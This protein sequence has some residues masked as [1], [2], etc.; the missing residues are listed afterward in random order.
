MAVYNRITFAGNG[1]QM[2]IRVPGTVAAEI[3]AGEF[4]VLTSNKAIRASSLGDSGTLA[5]NQQAFKNVFQG[6]SMDG[7]LANETR[8]IQIATGGEYCH[9]CAALGQAYDAGQFIGAA[10]TGSANA[11]G[12]SDTIVI[13]V[14]TAA[15]A[16]GKLSR[17]A[18]T[19]DTKLYWYLN[20]QTSTTGGVQATVT[21]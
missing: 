15:L 3:K 18:A 19:G 10:G 16:I 11:V 20:P 21:S 8:D 5:Q 1:D 9:P 14:A 4:M 2:P 7:K 12:I 17:A 6:I 13:P